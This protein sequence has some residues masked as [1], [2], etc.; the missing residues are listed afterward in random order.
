M[1]K[2]I[3]HTRRVLILMLSLMAVGAVMVFAGVYLHDDGQILD[4]FQS[5]YIQSEVDS[6]DKQD[7]SEETDVDTDDALDSDSSDDE[8]IQDD[9]YARQDLY[10]EESHIGD[11]P[12][13]FDSNQDVMAHDTYQDVDYVG[14]APAQH[15]GS[16]DDEG[17]DDDNSYIGIAPFG[18]GRP[19][20]LTQMA[21]LLVMATFSVIPG[22]MVL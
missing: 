2:K 15:S 10:D 16:V 3:K 18:S 17:L 20:F 7:V 4:D 14:D 22:L 1:F 11:A 21:V 19:V 6:D 8:V 9:D 5:A 12:G 13:G